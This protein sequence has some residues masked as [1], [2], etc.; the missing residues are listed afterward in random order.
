[1]EK[2]KRGKKEEKKNYSPGNS[3]AS[4]KAGDSFIFTPLLLV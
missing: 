2:R 4:E 1:M 3:L